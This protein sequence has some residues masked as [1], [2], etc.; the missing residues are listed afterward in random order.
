MLNTGLAAPVTFVEEIPILF[1][2]I[3]TFYKT[4]PAKL[5]F[6][7]YRVWRLH[8]RPYI[9]TSGVVAN[10]QCHLPSVQQGRRYSNGNGKFN[11]GSETVARHNCGDAT[12]AQ[13]RITLQVF[14]YM[15]KRRIEA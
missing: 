4:L 14:A 12:T 8:F 7:Q 13:K 2:T 3:L 5:G 10:V 6:S 15:G 11:A 9:R 1:S